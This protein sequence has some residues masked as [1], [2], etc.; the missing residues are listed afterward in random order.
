M[1]IASHDRGCLEALAERTMSLR[2]G[3]LG[4]AAPT[5]GTEVLV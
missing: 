2:D 4:A 3:R 1:I 5:M